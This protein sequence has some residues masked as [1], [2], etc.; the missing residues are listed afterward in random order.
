MTWYAAHV[1]MYTEFKD[2]NQDK[3]PIWENVHLVQA[4]SEEEAFRRACDIGRASEGDSSGTYFYE[5]RP[6]KWVFAGVRKLIQCKDKDSQPTD[7]TEV[8]YSVLEVPTRADLD[9][10]ASGETTQVLYVE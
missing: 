2:G 9:K 10:L 4:F 6:A 5:D 7:G 3:Y 8:S 1:I